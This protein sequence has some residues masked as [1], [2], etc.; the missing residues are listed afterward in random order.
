MNKQKNPIKKLLKRY[1]LDCDIDT[2]KDLAKDVGMDYQTLR[3]RLV[4]PELFR[5]YEIR[6][7]NETLHFSDEDLLNLIKVGI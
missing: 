3:D 1:M 6:A 4:R 7:L 2:F 5:A